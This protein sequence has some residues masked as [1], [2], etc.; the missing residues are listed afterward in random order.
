ME[1]RRIVTQSKGTEF[2]HVNQM[3]EICTSSLLFKISP[4]I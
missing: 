2:L 4:T 3:Q 1:I